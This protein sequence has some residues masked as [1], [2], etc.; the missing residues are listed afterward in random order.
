MPSR[1]SPL[2]QAVPLKRGLGFR[3]LGE[4]DLATVGD[5]RRMLDTL[6][7]GAEGV[8]IDLAGLSF[9]DA[10]G[11]HT[12]EEYAGTL[13]GSA[14]LVL[15][16]APANIRRVFALTGADQNPDI[17]LRDGHHG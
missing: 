8:L 7:P 1:T 5:L 17:E 13:N 11:L 15:A 14:P 10:S 3:L 9:M 2:F 6:P 4:L 12:F 16:N